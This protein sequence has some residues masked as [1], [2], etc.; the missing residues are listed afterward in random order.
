[1]AKYRTLTGLKRAVR[2]PDQVQQVNHW[3]EGSV[4]RLQ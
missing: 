4:I 1:M 3:K 2:Q